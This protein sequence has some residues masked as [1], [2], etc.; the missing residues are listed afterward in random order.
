MYIHLKW[1]NLNTQ[2]VTINIY[3]SATTID[4]ANPGT[5]LVTLPSSANDYYDRTVVAGS[6]YYYVIEF[7][8][9]K[10]KVTSRNY[11]FTA[12]YYR[13]HGNNLVVVGDDNYGFMGQFTLPSVN[14]FI[15]LLGINRATVGAAD[16]TTLMSF[17]FSIDG[18]VYITVIVNMTWMLATDYATFAKRATPL[19]V[20]IDGFNYLAFAPNFV[21][22]PTPSLVNG[23]PTG[24]NT[25]AHKLVSCLMS[26]LTFRN[27][28]HDL[29][30]RVATYAGST[31][32]VTGDLGNDATRLP[33]YRADNDTITWSLFSGVT[34][35]S[36]EG[37]V[38]L[39][40]VE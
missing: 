40:L 6:S 4:R 34:T 38:I 36:Y 20:T 28:P 5:P 17:K 37:L 33:V 16:D 13:G 10:G 19:P 39:E 7:V 22:L 27:R 29:L 18:K 8:S 32:W 26:N 11:Q 21:G 2:D 35:N 31:S 3:R 12:Q 1:S 24:D 14:A 30:G 23:T 9:T 15:K 25:L